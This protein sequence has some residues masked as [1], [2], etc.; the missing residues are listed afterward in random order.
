MAGTVDGSTKEAD[1]KQYLTF[2]TRRAIGR[3]FILREQKHFERQ[4][5]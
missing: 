4:S 1:R 2:L 3:R 5:S